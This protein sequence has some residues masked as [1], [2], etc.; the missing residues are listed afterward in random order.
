VADHEAVGVERLPS[1]ELWRGVD[2]FFDRAIGLDKG[3]SA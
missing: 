2:F 3:K 1:A